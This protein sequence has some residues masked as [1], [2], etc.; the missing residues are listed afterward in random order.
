MFRLNNQTD[1]QQANSFPEWS[2]A[3]GYVNLFDDQ[4]KFSVGK[5]GGGSPWATGGPEMWEELE[6]RMGVRFEYKPGYVPGLNVGFVVNDF[7]NTAFQTGGGDKAT[8]LDYLTE[9]VLGV[10]YDHELFGAR[11]AYRLDTPNDQYNSNDEGANLIY[12]LEEKVLQNY[13]P[14]LQVWANGHYKGIG[15]DLDEF[16]TFLNWLYIQYDRNSGGQWDNFTGQLKIGYDIVEGRSL[17]HLR[18]SFYYNLFNNLL[19]VGTS[20]TFAQDFGEN[21]FIAGSPYLYWQIEPKVQVNLGS[22]YA[23][24]VFHFEDKYKY[25]DPATGLPRE[26]WTWMNLRFG[27]TF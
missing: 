11:F 27:M 7:N 12:R 13:V 22:A 20:F 8:L 5:L 24:F 19:N 9:S 1:V 2:Y 18:P 21:K 14:G 6:T 15:T 17:L 3:F 16:I 10:R 26:Q 4:F 25:N 23:A